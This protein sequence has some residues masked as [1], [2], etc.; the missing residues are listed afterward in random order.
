MFVVAE[1]VSLPGFGSGWPPLITARLTAVPD[2][3]GLTVMV[4]TAVAPDAR[5]PPVGV[6]TTVLP[7]AVQVPCGE[8]AETKLT[9]EGRVSV[10]VTPVAG[11]G[12]LLVA[13]TV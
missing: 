11:S 3:V 2:V 10:T 6:Q 1:A 9:C 7:V 4:K 13:V 12:P 5:L 8:V